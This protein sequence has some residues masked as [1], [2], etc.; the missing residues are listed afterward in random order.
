M[1]CATAKEIAWAKLSA[2][3]TATMQRRGNN[4]LFI[5]PLLL[6]EHKN[7]YMFAVLNLGFQERETWLSPH[8]KKGDPKKCANFHVT[9]RYNEM[10]Y[11]KKW[12]KNWVKG[13]ASSIDIIQELQQT[14]RHAKTN[15]KRYHDKTKFY[16]VHE[17]HSSFFKIRNILFCWMSYF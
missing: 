16:K 6:G 8:P 9:K 13:I 1:Q 2:Y 15:N 17:C 7:D 14:Y 12:Y 3:C 10:H 5:S 11:F 4:L